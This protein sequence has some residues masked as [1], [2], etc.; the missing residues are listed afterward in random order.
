MNNFYLKKILINN[1]IIKKH[2][3]I[4]NKILFFF[5]QFEFDFVFF[6]FS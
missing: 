3:E 2:F 6:Y 4:K 1:L 5:K